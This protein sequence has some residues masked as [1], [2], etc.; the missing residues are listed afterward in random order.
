MSIDY[1]RVYQPQDAINIGCDPVDYPTMKYIETYVPVCTS[2]LSL[3]GFAILPTTARY[4]EAYTNFNLTLWNA[5][6]YPSEWPKNRLDG[7][8]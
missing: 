2:V 7:G 6:N 5:P 3:I 8:C 4:E 1:I